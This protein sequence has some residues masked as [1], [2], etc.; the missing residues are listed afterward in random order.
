MLNEDIT[1]NRILDLMYDSLGTKIVNFLKD[2]DVNEVILNPDGK[3]W[4]V[5][6]AKGDIDTG[7][8][9][10]ADSARQVILQAASLT[11]QICN[12][13]NPILYTTL[14]DGSRFTGFLPGVVS[15]PSFNIRKHTHSSQH[16]EDYLKDG[17]MTQR[18]YDVIIQAIKDKR[19]IVVAGGM[20]SGKTTLLNAILAKVSSTQDRVVMIEDTPELKCEAKNLLSLKTTDHVNQMA[21]ARAVLR[22]TPDRLVMGEIRGDEALA[23]MDIWQVGH[24]GGCATVHSNNAQHTL[25]RLEQLISRV[26]K[27]KPQEAIGDAVGMIIYIKL[28]G[29]GRRIEEILAVNGWNDDMNKYN[30][31]RVC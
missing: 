2:N 20:G 3:I 24:G 6:R 19:N 13:D 15:Q 18:Q 12:E 23:L 28:T 30:L 31:E 29:N 11:E 7:Y 27:T 8:T 14:S 26:S 16:L 21:L 22:T 25:K 10:E 4:I 9:L 5:T 1:Q 17:I